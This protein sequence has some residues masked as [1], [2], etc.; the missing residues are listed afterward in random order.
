MEP[1]TFIK[2]KYSRPKPVSGYRSSGGVSGASKK[3]R[4]K[5]PNRTKPTIQHV[6]VMDG[7]TGKIR[8]IDRPI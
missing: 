7:A 6:M 3:R 8:W 1:V 4:H 5:N 2:A